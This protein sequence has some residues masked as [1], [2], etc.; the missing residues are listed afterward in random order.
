MFKRSQKQTASR[1]K[2]HEKHAG[3]LD[4]DRTAGKSN[5]LTTD[6][7]YKQTT[8]PE[9]VKQKAKRTHQMKKKRAKQK[10]ILRQQKA[11]R[12]AICYS[13]LI[14]FLFLGIFGLII[15]LTAG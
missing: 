5:V 1:L 6:K 7:Q 9:W 12:K 8:T 3:Q 4:L 15:G 11:Y 10:A 14:V 2:Y 13:L